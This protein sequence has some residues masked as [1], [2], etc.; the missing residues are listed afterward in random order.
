MGDKGSVVALL[1]GGLNSAT[2]VAVMLEDGYEVHAL[3][4]DYLVGRSK[5]L[6][7]DA[8]ERVA[9]SLPIKSH[10]VIRLDLS[11]Y[12]VNYT[13]LGFINLIMSMG[14][15]YTGLVGADGLA[16][17]L[18]VHSL[19]PE[20]KPAYMYQFSRLA[21]LVTGRDSFEVHAP[22]LAFNKAEV[23]RCGTKLGLDYSLT[24]TCF[25]RLEDL[26]CGICTACILRLNG[27]EGAGVIDPLTYVL[28]PNS[29]WDRC[30]T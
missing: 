7:M 21:K 10:H 13:P 23:I 12:D 20:G 4:I 29:R 24:Q 11:E 3:T 30:S 6:E 22:L 2:N 1:S 5:D 28:T 8:V 14:L 15:C 27:F 26:N 19:Y 16:I 25:D 17:G 9:L 18:D